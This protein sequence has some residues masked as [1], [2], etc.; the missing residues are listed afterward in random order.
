MEVRFSGLPDRE[1]WA[2]VDWDADP[3]WEF[4]TAESMEPEQLRARCRGPASGAGKSSPLLAA[5]IS[6]Q[7]SRGATAGT[8]H[9]AGFCGISSRKP[10]ATPAT[11]TSSARRST[12]RSASSRT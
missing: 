1:P 5:R 11:P 2:S 6:C 12:A 7:R 4:R 3:N 8:S 9:S 10:L